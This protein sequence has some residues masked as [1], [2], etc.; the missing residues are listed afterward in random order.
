MSGLVFSSKATLTIFYGQRALQH[1]EM[2]SDKKK[3][4]PSSFY[5]YFFLQHAKKKWIF[6]VGSVYKL[7]YICQNWP[8]FSDISQQ[9]NFILF[10]FFSDKAKICLSES[11]DRKIYWVWPKQPE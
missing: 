6:L 11:V 3:K 10:Y 4:Q 8:I 1:V 7:V 2:V 5:F 9:G